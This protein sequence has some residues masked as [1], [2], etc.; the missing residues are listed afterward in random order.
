MLTDNPERSSGSLW[1]LLRCEINITDKAL[2][3]KAVAQLTFG[4]KSYLS[5]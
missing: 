2:E 3:L 1:K 5:S 4:S